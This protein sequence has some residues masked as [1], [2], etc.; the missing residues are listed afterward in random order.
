MNIRTVLFL[1]LDFETN[2]ETNKVKHYTT[3]L[4]LNSFY[5]KNDVVVVIVVKVC[6]SIP[7]N[8]LAL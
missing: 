6:K 2:T 5:V 3:A 1:S 7:H 8:L 4:N